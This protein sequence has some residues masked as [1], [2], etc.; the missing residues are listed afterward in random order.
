[1]VA[2][3]PAHHPLFEVVNGC[4]QPKLVF[5]AD[6]GF[7]FVEFADFWRCVRVVSIGESL[8]DWLHPSDHRRMMYPF[9]PL[10]GS[11]LEGR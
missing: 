2:Q 8:T 10:N 11:K 7:P 3:S 6:K 5:S 4:L 1:M 9:A